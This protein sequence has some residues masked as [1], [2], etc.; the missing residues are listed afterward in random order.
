MPAALIPTQRVGY[1][2]AFW[3]IALATPST[4]STLARVADGHAGYILT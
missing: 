2:R 1:I 4:S 3:L